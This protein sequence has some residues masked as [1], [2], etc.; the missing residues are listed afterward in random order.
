MVASQIPVKAV[1]D[2][3]PLSRFIVP[4]ILQLVWGV[5]YQP[6]FVFFD[7]LCH[8]LPVQTID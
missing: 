4:T 6:H 7:P 2:T 1:H 5:L 3:T 8:E